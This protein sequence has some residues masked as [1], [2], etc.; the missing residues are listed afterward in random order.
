[1]LNQALDQN[2][3]SQVHKNLIGEATLIL[4]RAPKMIELESIIPLFIANGEINAALKLC[5]IKAKACP[6]ELDKSYDIV[7]ELIDAIQSSIVKRETKGKYS[8]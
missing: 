7:L 3:Q 1:L 8:K 4:S 5:L 6:A 2:A